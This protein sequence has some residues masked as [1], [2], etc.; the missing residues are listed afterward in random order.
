MVDDEVTSC[1]VSFCLKVAKL[2]KLFTDKIPVRKSS[3]ASAGRYRPQ[4]FSMM[5]ISGLFLQ[6]SYVYRVRLFY[7]YL[8]LNVT[9]SWMIQCN[10]VSILYFVKDSE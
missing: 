7:V 9:V 2:C 10:K 8:G 4:A 5:S 3:L 6:L 1:V